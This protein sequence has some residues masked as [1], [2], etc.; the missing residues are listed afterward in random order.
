MQNITGGTCTPRLRRQISEYLCMPLI[1]SRLVT[2]PALLSPTI[3][4]IVALLFHVPNFL[5][6][7]LR[8]LRV[9]AWRGTT[10]RCVPL[11]ILYARLGSDDLCRVL[12]S[13]HSPTGCDITSNIGTKKAALK[14]DPEIHL[15]GF[16]TMTPLT[17]ATILHAEQ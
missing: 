17:S 6:K 1:V 11:D 12:P 4:T 8:E 9:R 10:T 16:G 15:H 5:Q 14:V 13:L 2:Q 7:G 3:H